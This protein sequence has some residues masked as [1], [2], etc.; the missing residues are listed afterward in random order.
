MYEERVNMNNEDIV[1]EFNKLHEE[2]ASLRKIIEILK[3]DMCNPQTTPQEKEIRMTENNKDN[4][5]AMWSEV[6]QGKGRTETTYSANPTFQQPQLY[7]NSKLETHNFVQGCN[8]KQL[9][10]KLTEELIPEHVPSVYSSQNSQFHIIAKSRTGNFVQ[11]RNN[12]KRTS[13][14]PQKLSYKEHVHYHHNSE[15]STLNVNR[16]KAV[17][18]ESAFDKKDAQ[19]EI[20]YKAGTKRVRP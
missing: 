14:L 9:N 17:S 2:I 19:S 8:S 16:R 12:T 10:N 3:Y 5:Q 15:N 7:T 13:R 6:V 18:R 4:D 1:R 20:R 11:R